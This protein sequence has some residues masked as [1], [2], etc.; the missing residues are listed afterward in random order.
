MS[1]WKLI[2]TWRTIPPARLRQP[3]RLWTALNRPNVLIKVPATADGLPAIQQ[4]I[5]EGISVNVTLLFGLP[6]YRQVADAYI[7]GIEAR[8]AQGRPVKHM[9]SV[10]TLVVGRRPDVWSTGSLGTTIECGLHSALGYVTP[11]DRLAGRQDAIYADRDRKLRQA[12]IH[13]AP[14][15]RSHAA[16]GYEKKNRRRG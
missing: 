14:P 5:S 2:P 1:A 6:R 12:R 4:L 15:P 3:V 16:G 10:A 13:R 8:A 7:A 9:A 11:A